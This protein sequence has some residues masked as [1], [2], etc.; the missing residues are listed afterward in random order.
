MDPAVSKHDLPDGPCIE[1]ADCKFEKITLC[2][3]NQTGSVAANVKFLSCMDEHKGGTA[4]ADG[5]KCAA[6]INSP[7]DLAEACFSGRRG[8]E[9]LTAAAAVF[10][11]SGVES[12][13]TVV[14]MPGD[15]QVDTDYDAIKAALCNA[16]STAA[17]CGS[18]PRPPAPTP[19]PPAPTPTPGPKPTP[20]P[21]PGPHKKDLY[22]CYM[23]TCDQ[24]PDGTLTVQDCISTCRHSE[25][26][27]FFRG[28]L[29]VDEGVTLSDA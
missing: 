20:T 9:L 29:P 2:V 19:S 12:V 4:V 28:G 21:T 25:Q 8:L 15:T 7:W 18:G 17:V 11:A 16:G 5:K 26:P 13:P 24:S 6:A 22:K 10:D 3:F 1:E 23:G 27:H 14:V